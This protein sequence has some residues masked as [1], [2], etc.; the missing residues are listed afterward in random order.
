M[1]IR[2]SCVL[3]EMVLAPSDAAEN[4]TRLPTCLLNVIIKTHGIQFAAS[5]FKVSQSREICLHFK[6]DTRGVRFTNLIHPK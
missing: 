1:V 2:D 3:S 4:V 5:H 6:T